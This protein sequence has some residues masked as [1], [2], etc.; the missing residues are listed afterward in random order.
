MNV[1]KTILY[2]IW[3]LTIISLIF[4]PKNR[5]RE[6]SISFLFQQSITWFF[7]LLVVEWHLIEYP[8][9]E[10]ASVNKTSFTFEFFVYPVISAF[11]AIYYP[12]YRS[13]WIRFFY[14]SFFST[15][16]TIVEAIFE[17]YTDL[18]KYVHWE[19]YYTWPS[20]FTTLCLLRFFYK[21][22]FKYDHRES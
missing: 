19:W 12:D 22:F 13:L 3:S 1:E 21:W 6:A 10:L 7:G 2:S 17:N 16:I 14:I 20:V 4:I 8:V 5:Q 9:R 18:V 11:F 15:S